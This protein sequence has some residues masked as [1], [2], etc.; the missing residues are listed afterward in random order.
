MRGAFCEAIAESFLD[1]KKETDIYELYRDAV[2]TLVAV[3]PGQIPE[4]RS[5]LTKDLIITPFQF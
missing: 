2:K 1:S 3:R 5:T 4:L